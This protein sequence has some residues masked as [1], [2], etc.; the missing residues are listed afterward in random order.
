LL[1][2]FFMYFRVFGVV[3][4][5]S[6]GFLFELNPKVAFFTSHGRQTGRFYD[7]PAGKQSRTADGSR[8]L[9]THQGSR[10]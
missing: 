2:V 7:F 5:F 1:T 8:G 9:S 10:A 3:R 4:G 6:C